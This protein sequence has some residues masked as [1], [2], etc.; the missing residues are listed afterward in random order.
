MVEISPKSITT[1]DFIALSDW[2]RDEPQLTYGPLTK[3]LEQNFAHYVGSEYAVFVNSGSSANLLMAQALKNYAGASIT[4]PSLSWSTTVA[5]FKQLGYEMMFQ[6]ADPKTLS[7]K[8]GG[9]GSICIVNVLGIEN[10][11][12]T[13]RYQYVVYDNC[14]AINLKHKGDMCT[15]STFYSHHISTIEGGFIT[16]NFKDLYHY[17]LSIRSHG[18]DRDYT[19]KDGFYRDFN[20]VATGYNVRNTEIAAF[21]GLRQLER[22]H[23]VITKRTTVSLWYEKY[24]H[25]PFWKLRGAHPLFAY[26]IIHPNRERITEALKGVC[27]TRPL[28]A[29]NIL[30]HPFMKDHMDSMWFS[31]IIHDSGFYVPC[32]QDM[33]KDDVITITNIINDFTDWL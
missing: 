20:F 29:G 11:T 4:L 31:D 5:P 22:I 30:R 21:L 25:N 2:L 3:T 14:E 9:I 16:T 33:S 15:Y 8:G 27:A 10:N 7:V 26:P 6:D 12:D 24:L 23:Q 13:S 1:E 17:L 18:W 19:Q 28:L 32:H